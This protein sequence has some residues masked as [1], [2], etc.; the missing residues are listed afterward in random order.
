V[1]EIRGDA[2]LAS[3]ERAAD[4][5]SAALSFQVD[6]TYHLSRIK[7]N[8]RPSIRVGIAMVQLLIEKGADIN[9]RASGMNLLHVV[10]STTRVA[11]AELLIARGTDI[12]AEDNSGYTPLDRAIGGDTKMIELLERH[13]AKC[14][15][16]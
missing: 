8:L 10:A 13:G 9:T 7:D 11:I 3:F 1:L 4:A 2:L 14:G 6:H 16:C 12:N 5:V 15:S